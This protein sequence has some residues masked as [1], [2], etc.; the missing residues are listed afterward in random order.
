MFYVDGYNVCFSL[1]LEGSSLEEERE[2][3]LSLIGNRSDIVVFDG[4]E[5]SRMH[6]GNL[7]IVYAKTADDYILEEVERLSPKRTTVVTA[8]RA[9]AN[10]AREFGAKIVSPADYVAK[11]R[12]S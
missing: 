12:K 4:P 10:A 6:R 5:F 7:E 9:L 3:L 11:L 8:D 2:S 1:D